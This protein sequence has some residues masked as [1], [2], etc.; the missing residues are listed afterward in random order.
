MNNSIT[1]NYIWIGRPSNFHENNIGSGS[2]FPYLHKTVLK[3]IGISNRFTKYLVVKIY[4][5][6]KLCLYYF[7]DL[8]TLF[9]AC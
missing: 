9:A 2:K 4:L 3:N 1:F 8:L 7:L 5:Y 6:F